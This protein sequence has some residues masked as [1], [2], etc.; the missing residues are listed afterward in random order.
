LKQRSKHE[1]PHCLAENRLAKSEAPRYLV[2]LA[3][4]SAQ[5]SR[6]FAQRCRA[7]ALKERL[8]GFETSG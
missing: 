6:Q 7:L 4:R 5:Q 2:R 8:Y 1:S 3:D